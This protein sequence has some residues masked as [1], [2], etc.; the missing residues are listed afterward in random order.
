MKELAYT[1]FFTEV[2]EKIE[3]MNPV[4]KARHELVCISGIKCESERATLHENDNEEVYQYNSFINII[5][6]TR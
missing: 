4:A 6:F 2:A 3:M 1:R 5:V